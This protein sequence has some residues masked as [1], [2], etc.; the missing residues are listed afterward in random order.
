MTSALR[1][2]D[3]GAVSAVSSFHANVTRSSKPQWLTF[4]SLFSFFRDQGFLMIRSLTVLCAHLALVSLLSACAT[5][6][7]ALE[8]GLH[9]E[10]AG[11]PDVVYVVNHGWHTGLVLPAGK[12]QSLIPALKK[13]FG[14][15]SHIEFGWGDKGFYQANEIT[16]ELALRAMFWSSGSV[17]H[18]VAVPGRPDQYFR[19]SQVRTLCL[20]GAG[21]ASL[22]AFVVSSFDRGATGEVVELKNGLYGDS[23]F[24]AGRGSYH[25]MNTCNKWTAKALQSAGL[26]LSPTFMLTASSVMDHAVLAATALESSSGTTRT[27]GT[28]VAAP[29][30]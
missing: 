15:V 7:R 12:V 19:N 25:L 17:I 27:C 30:Q 9:G 6:P 22:L 21:H 24:Y 4:A 26:D 10:G 3:G 16:T 13:R 23:Q 11:E 8:P 5:E 1:G 14:D 20:D 28:H 18:A 29:R 2:F